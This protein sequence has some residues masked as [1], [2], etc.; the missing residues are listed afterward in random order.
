MK[1]LQLIFVL[2]LS[3]ASLAQSVEIQ[4]TE[5][6]RHQTIINDL[7]NIKFV[8]FVCKDIA[9]KGKYFGIDI[10]RFQN[11]VPDTIHKGLENCETMKLPV[12]MPT[13]DTA[14]YMYDPCKSSLFSD[15]IDS[16]VTA[17]AGKQED[18]IL[19]VLIDKN[20]AKTKFDI[21]GEPNFVLQ[22]ATG[23]NIRTVPI[24]EPTPIA[25]YFGGYQSGN[26]RFYCLAKTVG[27]EEMYEAFQVEDYYVFY[28]TIKD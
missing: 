14:Y 21:H 13:G 15:D 1:I 19:H 2:A 27:A 23:D 9:A 5:L 24:N 20:H 4:F 16:M 26:G 6:T 11:G 10:I 8:E 12:V 28:L 22:N 18:S 25:L 7:N 3:S 17:F